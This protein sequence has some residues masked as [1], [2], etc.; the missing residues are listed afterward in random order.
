MV[1]DTNEDDA[2]LHKMSKT[3]ILESQRTDDLQMDKISVQIKKTCVDLSRKE[4]TKAATITDS[5]GCSHFFHSE[6]VPMLTEDMSSEVRCILAKQNPTLVISTAFKLSI[7]QSDLA[8]LEEGC[9]LNDNVIDLKSHTIQCYDSM[10]QRHDD[11]CHMLLK[12][13]TEE[14]KVKKGCILETY[15]WTTGRMRTHAVPRQTNGND[16]GVFAC[17]YADFLSQGNQL[18]FRQCDIPL[19]RKLMVWEIAHETAL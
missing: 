19:F 14:Y 3:K 15:R 2:H 7:T 18:T 1:A 8:T 10:G 17:K 16:C 12:Y 6:N 11:I 9:W 13:F 5:D 4:F